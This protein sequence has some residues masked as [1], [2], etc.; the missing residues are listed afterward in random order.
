ME[1]ERLIV[2]SDFGIL[3]Q[4]AA[5]ALIQ[6]LLFLRFRQFSEPDLL[7]YAITIDQKQSRRTANL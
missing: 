7:H 6:Y 1:E 2:L 5:A 4:S 3:K